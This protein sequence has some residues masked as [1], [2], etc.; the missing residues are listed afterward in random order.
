MKTTSGLLLRSVS[1]LCFGVALLAQTSRGETPQ[2]SPEADGKNT[3]R[4]TRRAGT[5]CD[6]SGAPVS[7][8]TVDY[9]AYEEGGLALKNSVATGTNG[10]FEMQVSQDTGFLVARKPGLALAWKQFYAGSR[11]ARNGQDRLVLAHPAAFMGRV[12]DEADQPVSN[13]TVSVAAAVT[14][15]VPESD[16]RGV[17]FLTGKPVRDGFSARTDAAGH[18]RIKGFPTNATARFAVR[19]PGKALRS[20]PREGA[21]FDLEE[22]PSRG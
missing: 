16:A 17:S 9:W 19:L 20:P 15:M 14:D 3:A 5:V 10:S 21:G 13:A 22:I 6:A 4:L 8:A 1:F 11:P 12:V 18:F 2:A 7:G